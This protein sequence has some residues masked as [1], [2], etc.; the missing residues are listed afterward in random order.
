MDRF[1]TALLVLFY[2]IILVVFIYIP[3]MTIR[4]IDNSLSCLFK[5]II[6]I[7]QRMI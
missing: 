6:V 5:L 4:A 3:I 1:L 2:F 7:K